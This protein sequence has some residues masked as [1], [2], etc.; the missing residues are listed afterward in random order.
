[1][2]PDERF[3]IVFV[4]DGLRPD[5]ITLE[6]TPT[7]LRLRRD[8]VDW[9]NGHAVF[10]TVTRVNAASFSTG[11]QPGT[12]GIVGNRMYVPAVDPTRAFDT[13]NYR[14]L[15]QL[16]QATGGRLLLAPTLAER[17]QKRGLQLAG[18]SSGSTGSAFLLN[19]KASSGV[20]VLVNGYLDPGKTVAYPPEVSEAIL[21]RFGP[22]PVKEPGAARFDA[23]VA[24]T[25][26]VLREYVLPDLRPTVVLNW[27]TEPDHSQHHVGVGSS[28]AREALRNDD[29]QIAA[30]LAT[31][32]DL[33]LAPSTDVLVVSDHGFT[34][35]TAG[36]DVTR[37]LVDAGLK[38]S[39][40]SSDVVLASSGQAVALYVEAHDRER[41]GR[42]A[43]FVH[44]QEWGGVVFTA[45][46][47]SGD[48]RGA[49]EGT[50]SLE[51]IHMASRERGPDLVFTFPW[52]SRPNAFG[53]PGSD[54]ANV[55][56]GATPYISDHGS[57]SPWNVRSTFLAWGA[58]F[59]ERTIVRAPAG[60][61]DVTPTILAL[62][63]IA[64]AERLDGRVLAEALDG[65]PDPEQVAVGTRVHTVT[66]GGY[67][68][69]LQ[70]SEVD[71]RG[72]VDKSWRIR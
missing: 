20:G 31:V 68:A 55:S 1:M 13:G 7:L 47:D 26:R 34:T 52:S 2:P 11:T 17:L 5:A 50:F 57:M 23:S 9:T 53:V 54:V 67:R 33:D 46:R 56:G 44:S 63:G 49:V 8:G 37:F 41:I 25:Q 28:A 3:V 35:N 61:V 60:N 12:H 45:G 10:P 27:L 19:P 69:A 38:A 29:R 32:D 16:D 71:G 15:V 62:L 64:E 51:L 21:A 70:L 18:V 65:G 24:W 22:A 43:R 30:V 42:L 36:V 58:D 6:D 40:D 48:P 4:V 14:N 59:K 39:P 66:A 72:Y